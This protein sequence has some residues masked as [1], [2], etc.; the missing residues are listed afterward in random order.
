MK[1]KKVNKSKKTKT[2]KKDI[3]GKKQVF[4]VTVDPYRQDCI[5]VVNGDIDDAISF[6]QKKGNSNA[7]KVV[8]YYEKNKKDYEEFKHEKNT[9]SGELI[10]GF[11]KG[12]V[13]TIS[14]QDS[15]IST[16]GVI[17]HECTHLAH[18]VLQRAGIELTTESEEAFTY[19]QQSI[20]E[21]I[22]RKIY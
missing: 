5:V 17:S 18:Y 8:E 11:P 2:V 19:L 9:G 13:M 14:H 10:T 16:V 1:K 22:L 3:W 12:Y 21:Q 6:L 20:L 4:I 7:K 15:W